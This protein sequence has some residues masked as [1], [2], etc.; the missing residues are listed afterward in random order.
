MVSSVTNFLHPN[1][2]S[3]S[4]LSALRISS[5]SSY[6][7]RT[8]PPHT[9]P[10]LAISPYPP[11]YPTSIPIPYPYPPPF[12]SPILHPRTRSHQTFR[13]S[14]LQ[15]RIPLYQTT[16]LYIIRKPNHAI[17][18]PTPLSPR[19]LTSLLPSSK[20]HNP[21][22]HSLSSPAGVQI[23]RYFV[24]V[25]YTATDATNGG[26]VVHT[27]KRGGAGGDADSKPLSSAPYQQRGQGVQH[28]GRRTSGQSKA[29]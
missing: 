22:S 14:P 11:L 3:P 28:K 10:N 4:I 27:E 1:N 15:P 6:P 8:K 5:R 29:I 7:E 24:I 19:P 16:R 20:Y 13:N 17:Y 26:P 2:F 25:Q 23:R 21:L 18:I 12:A 9:H